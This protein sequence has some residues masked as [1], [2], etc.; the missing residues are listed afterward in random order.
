MWVADFPWWGKDNR[1]IIMP[2]LR[3]GWWLHGAQSKVQRW[4][5]LTKQGSEFLEENTSYSREPFHFPVS[6]AAKLISE[7]TLLQPQYSPAQPVIAAP[8]RMLRGCPSIYWT[9]FC[10]EHKVSDFA[11]ILSLTSSWTEGQKNLH[12]I[13]LGLD[14]CTLLIRC[15]GRLS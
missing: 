9:S 5:C 11:P 12:M 6:P 2:S 15:C 14:D 4:H 1:L 8:C 3:L 10:T 13:P 7:V